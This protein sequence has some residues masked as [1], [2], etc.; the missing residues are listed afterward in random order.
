LNIPGL[1]NIKNALGAIAVCHHLGIDF[2][3][4]KE[5]ISE[6]TGVYRRFEIKGEVGGVMVV[7]D[8]AHHPTEIKATLQAARTGWQRRIV[9]IF[10]PH[11]Y[12]RTQSFYKEFGS[13]FDD[14]DIAI[15]TD[16]YPAREVPI[17]GVTGKL[18]ADAAIQ[19]GHK[20]IQYVANVDD[21][22]EEL[23]KTLVE[24]D[25]V[26]TIGAGNIFN[27]S[28]KILKMESLQYNKK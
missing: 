18:I 19:F 11:T 17:E 7:D 12:T 4:I 10:Q 2:D 15:I 27:L 8:Y 9:A 14:A 20:G 16:V 5:A 21:V 1:H 6:F 25:M 23:L 13:S 24:G 22:Y 3:V 26:I 28:N